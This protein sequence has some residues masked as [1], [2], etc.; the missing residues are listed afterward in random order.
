MYLKS[1]SSINFSFTFVDK[2]RF[3]N[4]TYPSNSCE[5]LVKAVYCCVAKVVEVKKNHCLCQLIRPF[6]KA[7]L[8]VNYYHNQG[9]IIFNINVLQN[10]VHLCL[11]LRS[12]IKVV[13]VQF[14]NIICLLQTHIALFIGRQSSAL[15]HTQTIFNVFIVCATSIA[16]K[17]PVALQIYLCSPFDVN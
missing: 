6:I 11:V 4:L 16:S 9:K 8:L 3:C 17:L 7:R 12:S 1:Q 15:E 5:L 14:L 10:K 2:G 13:A